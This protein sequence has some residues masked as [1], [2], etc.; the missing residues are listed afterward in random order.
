VFPLSC[1][2]GTPDPLLLMRYWLRLARYSLKAS[3]G[4]AVLGKHLLRL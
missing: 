2:A 4:H 1:W 3:I